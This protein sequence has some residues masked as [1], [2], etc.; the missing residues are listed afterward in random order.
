MTSLF[1]MLFDK[2][3]FTH[4]ILKLNCFVKGGYSM[5]V[6]MLFFS[7]FLINVSIVYAGRVEELEAEMERSRQLLEQLKVEKIKA[8]ETEKQRSKIEQNLARLNDRLVASEQEF[9]LSEKEVNNSRSETIKLKADI[10]KAQKAQGP[11]Q[12]ALTD[13]L[14]ERTQLKK[15]IDEK[16]KQLDDL[17]IKINA[18][19]QKLAQFNELRD[20]AE[21]RT[22]IL[23]A[24]MV[25]NRQKV[26]DAES[27]VVGIEKEMAVERQKLKEIG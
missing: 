15:L 2:N 22:V 6:I 4:F 13:M 3:C 21:K 14:G 16:Q 10:E 5:R 19:K 26:K 7:V 27:I 24:E 12:D 11:I 25:K 23:D 18:Q 8:I 9:D 20:A 1:D 17:E